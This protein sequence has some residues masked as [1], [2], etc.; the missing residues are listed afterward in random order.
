ME[1]KIYFDNGSTSFPKAPGVSQ[2]VAGLLE[3][4]AFNINRG[5]YEEAYEVA[6]KVLDTREMLAALF[7][8]EHS[9]QVVFT[10]GI[11]YSLNYFIKGFLKS[12]DHV[13]VSGMEHNAVMRP[14]R[15]MEEKGVA[16]TV[17]HTDEEGNVQP[18]DV[19][20]EVKHNTRAVIMLHASNVCGTIVPIRDIGEVCKRHR[21]YLAVDTA[22]SAGTIEVDM[23][24][25]NI[26]F[27]AF[28][29]HKGLLG[30]QGIGGFLIS[31]ELDQNM[32]PFIAGGTG[33]QSDLLEMPKCLPDKYESGTMN[34]PGII[35]LHAALAYIEKEGIQKIHKKKMELTACFLEQVKQL[36]GVKIAGKQGIEN[37]VAVVSLDFPGQDNAVVAFRLEQE[38]GI[39]TRV[40]LHCAPMAHKSLHTYPQGTVRFAFSADNKIEEIESCITA[41]REL[42]SI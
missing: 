6:D 5:S 7:H 40:G 17:V 28:T 32:I 35:G 31:E 33:S 3:D 10:P 16:Y 38:Y 36:P 21:L 4:G 13:L 42:I 11:T 9:R 29:G 39:M 19:E 2:A 23:Q 1:N 12:G 30:P 26:D 24:Q 8:A 14:L 20:R 22:Q 25:M 41:F 27:L 15:Q 34:L 18:E 37:R